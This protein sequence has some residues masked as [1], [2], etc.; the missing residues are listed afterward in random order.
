MTISIAYI[1]SYSYY[2]FQK[3]EWKLYLYRFEKTVKCTRDLYFLNYSFKSK[4]QRYEIVCQKS[5]LKSNA[6][7]WII[8]STFSKEKEVIIIYYNYTPYEFARWKYWS[9]PNSVFNL[10]AN[11]IFYYPF[12]SLFDKIVLACAWKGTW[13]LASLQNMNVK[14]SSS[15][16]K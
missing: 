10:D 14:Q 4:I 11:F 12:W 3:I 15:S 1:C 13:T 9:F 8:A 7:L 6:T 16:S 2:I 5:N